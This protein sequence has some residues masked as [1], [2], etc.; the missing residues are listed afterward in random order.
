MDQVRP[1]S[2][3]PDSDTPFP[4]DPNRLTG[5]SLTV[6]A[7]SLFSGSNTTKVLV[8]H[9]PSNGVFTISDKSEPFSCAPAKVLTPVPEGHQFQNNRQAGNPR[10]IAVDNNTVILQS[11]TGQVMPSTVIVQ[12]PSAQS[13]TQLL[14]SSSNSVIS[15]VYGT[16]ADVTPQHVTVIPSSALLKRKEEPQQDEEAKR[17]RPEVGGESAE[18]EA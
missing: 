8:A 1:H 9:V 2:H 12:A 10:A 14:V 7:E 18:G 17:Q 13:T 6:S 16:T 3:Q 11:S 15:R 4:A 5:D